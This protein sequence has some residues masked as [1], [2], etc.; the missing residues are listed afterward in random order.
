VDGKNLTDT[1]QAHLEDCKNLT[2]LD[3]RKT[4]TTAAKLQELKAVL[5]KCKTEWDGGVI[6]PM[7][8]HEAGRRARARCRWQDEQDRACC[9]LGL[10]SVG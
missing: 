1:G 4:R 9:M 7:G 10:L 2:C 5:P 8:R 3:L 6:E